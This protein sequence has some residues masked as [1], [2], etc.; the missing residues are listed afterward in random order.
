M[1][2][3]KWYSSDGGCIQTTPSPTLHLTVDDLTGLIACDRPW[4][5]TED[6]N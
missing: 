1:G 2:E 4:T 6:R 3:T 5:E